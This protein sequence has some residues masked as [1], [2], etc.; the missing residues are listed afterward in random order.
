MEGS[1]RAIGCNCDGSALYGA[2]AMQLPSDRASLLRLAAETERALDE[3]ANPGNE[4]D[5]LQHANKLLSLG[6]IRFQLGELPEAERL[7]EQS[8]AAFWKV[9]LPAGKLGAAA[10]CIRQSTAAMADGR[11]DDALG[12]IERLVERCG[13]FPDF[14]DVPDFLGAAEIMRVGGLGAWLLLCTLVEDDGR[15][16]EAAG[17]ALALLDPDASPAERDLVGQALVGRA[18][19][20]DTLGHSQEAIEMYEKAI[21]WLEAEDPAKAGGRQAECLLRLAVVLGNLD[22]DEEATEVFARIATRFA[23]NT[24]QWA[25]DAVAVA[26]AWLEADEDEDEDED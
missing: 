8:A 4:E 13:G 18:K 7:C 25:Q 23:S 21:A 10:A 5:S 26:R 15:L 6:E 24:E 2:M 12:I 9:D 22:R 17:T 16:Y 19:T 11:Y 1:T 14:R 3:T 20:A